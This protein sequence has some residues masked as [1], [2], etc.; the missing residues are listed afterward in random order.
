VFR[1]DAVSLSIVESLTSTSS[2]EQV[3]ESVA[4]TIVSPN[5]PKHYDNFEER[6]YK[7]IA[8]VPSR[9]KLIFNSFDVEEDEWTGNCT[10]DYLEVSTFHLE[11]RKFSKADKPAR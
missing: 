5:Y 3:F 4:G 7:I 6:Y 11:T 8:P 1:T 2:N 10:Y 9:M